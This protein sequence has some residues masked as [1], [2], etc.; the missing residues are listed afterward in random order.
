MNKKV[1]IISYRL[2][3][4]VV[5]ILSL[6]QAYSLNPNDF[7]IRRITAPY[8]I[9][10]GNNPSIYTR[11]YVG[12]EVVNKPTSGITYSNLKFNI[13]SINS[14]IVGQDYT[15]IS[16]ANGIINVGTL[17]PGQSKV[18][19]YYVSYPTAQ[20]NQPQAIATFN[21]SLTDLTAT[22]K[23]QTENIY[24]RSSISANAG[25]LTQA[26]INNQDILGGYIL[27]TITYT[28][29]NVRNGDENDFQVA[30]TPGFDPTRLTLIS[31]EVLTS[32][33]PNINAGTTD[34]LY[35]ISGNGSPGA[36]V[37]ILWKFKITGYDFTSF[38][39]P[40]A[41]ATS[42]STN[43]KYALNTDLGLGSPISVSANA[44][45]LSITKTSDKAVY[46]STN[47]PVATFT[48]TI[49]NSGIF[50][51]SLDK[52]VDT[53][54]AG[55]AYQSLDLSS[56]I[57]NTNAV[58]LPTTGSSG[59]LVFEGG[60]TTGSFTSFEIPA[61]G[62][63]SLVYTATVPSGTNSNL[64]SGAGGFVG[65]SSI[66]SSNL[67]VSTSCELSPIAIDDN[68]TTNENE[69]INGNV[70]N[71]DTPS[72]DGGN[73]WG[74]VSTTP[75]GIL[76]FNN[77]GTFN[78]TPNAFFNG[79][80]TFYYKICDANSDCD[81][82]MVIITV[83]PVNN[84]PIAT[85]NSNATLVGTPVNGDVSSNDTPSG[86]GGNTWSIATEPN[87]GT[88]VFN[89]N[90]TYTYT[91]N[92]TF[93][94]LDTFYYRLCDVDGDCDTAIVV[95]T[96]SSPLPITLFDFNAKKLDSKSNIISWTIFNQSDLSYVILEKSFN[97]V[98][99]QSAATKLN[100]GSTQ[101]QHVDY[102]DKLSAVVFY[103]LKMY[104]KN[105]SFTYSKV[106]SVY[107][108][109]DNSVFGV[110]PNPTKSN[111]N[112]SYNSNKVETV[113]IFMYNAEGKLISRSVRNVVQ[114]I[115]I[116]NMDEFSSSAAGN[117][118]IEVYSNGVKSRQKLIKQ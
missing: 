71:N 75:N 18:C 63:L 42:G 53:L 117:Y 27:D 116:I 44:N 69:S 106:I 39:L 105:G 66:G 110:Y 10:D 86:D 16:P 104:E 31:T 73:S 80:D 79:N 84:F 50:P 5:T 118:W 13:T 58:S 94:G 1:K 89:T 33:V 51:V 85:E 67:I 11:A 103:R 74:L 101:F 17:A 90:G 15:L 47:N 23:N 30:V 62:S 49:S 3:L 91:P 37:K 83:L 32:D 7:T 46:C 22:P 100:A 38:L 88:I 112:I 56:G 12:F 29:G 109:T 6:T 78:Y 113:Q 64:A 81:T 77:D 19:Y 28:V 26:S 9:V 40:C 93:S 107:S 97:G 55:F 4:L 20:S 34:S 115:N 76:V 95:I 102:F 57:T 60:V 43:Y 45:T 35:F 14:S 65:I 96:V 72:S 41:G 114:G 52:I 24:N 70:S 92:P 25:G 111:F 59:V 108:K 99:F 68:F 8:F 98:D 87:N 48:I 21:L 61:G 36:S 54:P 82:A 2:M